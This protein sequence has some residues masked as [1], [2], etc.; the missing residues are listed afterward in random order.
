MHLRPMRF[1]GASAYDSNF[2][3]TDLLESAQGSERTA[4]V[5]NRSADSVPIV[6]PLLDQPPIG[7]AP[8]ANARIP[9]FV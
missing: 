9:P 4:A 2:L 1:A 3:E 8:A 6:G 5:Q 7:L